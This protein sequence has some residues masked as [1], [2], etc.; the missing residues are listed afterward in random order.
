MEKPKS[1]KEMFNGYN[2]RILEINGELLYVAT[3]IAKIL[4]IKNICSNTAKISQDEKNTI[5]IPDKNGRLQNTI[6]L[7][8]KGVFNLITKSNKKE[9]KPFQNWIYNEF[10]FPKHKHININQKESESFD[11]K[12]NI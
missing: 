9:A 8:E 5:N 10:L 3:D 11:I 2:V 12:D 1:L 6:V 7:N 4:K